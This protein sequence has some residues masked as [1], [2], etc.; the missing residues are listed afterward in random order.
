MIPFRFCPYCQAEL[1][2][3]R[4]PAN[5][6]RER[7]VCSACGFIQWGNSKASSS[8]IL[9]GEDGRILL[10]RRATEPFKDMWDIPGG[11][12]ESG[13][14]PAEG[15]VR[16]FL[17]E[18]RLEIAV[19]RMIGVYMDTYGPP[20]SEDTLN[21]YYE[22]RLIGGEMHP[23]DDVSELGWFEPKNLPGP[24]AFDNATQAYREW[25]TAREKDKKEQ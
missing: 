20:P 15:V 4:I 2:T 8:G 10:S 6:G 11:F 25:M 12:L 3:R 16:E 18:T 22:C 17:E 5:D 24:L 13:E 23:E 7:R 21:F 1:Q 9:V 14:H 19:T